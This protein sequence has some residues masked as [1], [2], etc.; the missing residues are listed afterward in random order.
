MNFRQ[1]TAFVFGLIEALIGFVIALVFC[2]ALMRYLGFPLLLWSI[3]QGLPMAIWALWLD[4]WLALAA[5]IVG[6][7]LWSREVEREAN[8]VPTYHRRGR[9]LGSDGPRTRH[10][11]FMKQYRQQRQN[12]RRKR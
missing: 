4:W 5:V 1:R 10:K 3:D 8:E 12:R 11:D 7:Y 6:L 9:D 2:T